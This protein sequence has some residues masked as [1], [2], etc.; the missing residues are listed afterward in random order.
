MVKQNFVPIY[1]LAKLS[2]EERNAYYL[3]VCEH[4]KIPADLNLLEFI[5]MDSGDSLRKLVLY[6]K[7]GGTDILRANL[8]I[9]VDSMEKEI[10]PDLVIFTAKGHD[11]TGRTDLAVGSAVIKNLSGQK[12]EYAIQT[13]QT[14]ATRRLTLQFA[15]GG[16]LD[17]SEVMSGV[18]NNNPFASPALSQLAAPPEVPK[19][20]MEKGKD[21]TEQQA[22]NEK[23]NKQIDSIVA[24]CQTGGPVLDPETLLPAE[25]PKR[26]PGPRRSVLNSPPNW[27]LKPEEEVS[28]SADILESK[29]TETFQELAEQIT[30]PVVLETAQQLVKSDPLLQHLQESKSELPSPK[31]AEELR[32][33]SGDLMESKQISEEI[34]LTKELQE[35]FLK[36]TILFD[37]P[38]IAQELR[39]S[40]GGLLPSPKEAE[41]LRP[42]LYHYIDVLTT[43]GGMIPSENIGGGYNKL[44]AFVLKTKGVDLKNLSITGWNELFAFFEEN[45]MVNGAKELVRHIDSVVEAK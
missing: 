33:K 36:T 20:N 8:G 26:R 21:I 5:W 45:L 24:A 38:G 30:D 11:H 19:P 35:N 9:S 15:G 12:L 31:Q 1:D 10:T 32:P 4:F 23:V 3:R 27:Q 44:N 25:L 2:E 22:A 40:L 39:Q 13:A 42:K 18:V 43:E 6:C 41:E 14:R 28:P 17:E 34:K 7:K 37:E 29:R 16:L